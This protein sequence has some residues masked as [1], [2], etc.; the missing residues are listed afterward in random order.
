MQSLQSKNISL[1]AI[2]NLSGAG[3]AGSPLYGKPRG[4][5]I[6]I[7]IPIKNIPIKT[8]MTLSAFFTSTT[9]GICNCNKIKKIWF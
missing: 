2:I 6:K 1:T 5:K 9:I 8:L 3:E 4:V 7:P